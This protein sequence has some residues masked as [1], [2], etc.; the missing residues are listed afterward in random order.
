MA[1]SSTLAAGFPI[2]V[3]ESRSSPEGRVAP[4]GIDDLDLA[5]VQR[6]M[7]SVGFSGTPQAARF[8]AMT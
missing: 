5:L 1:G 2:H 7:D 4:N 8:A 3:N 6:A